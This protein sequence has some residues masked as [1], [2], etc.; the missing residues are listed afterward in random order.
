MVIIAVNPPSRISW[1][2]SSHDWKSSSDS[3][4]IT[5]FVSLDAMRGEGM[6]NSSSLSKSRYRQEDVNWSQILVH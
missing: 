4:A 1:L 3:I 2:F 5:G 6:F